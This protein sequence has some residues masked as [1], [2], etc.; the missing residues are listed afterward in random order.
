MS[1]YAPCCYNDRD[2]SMTARM[3]VQDTIAVKTGKTSLQEDDT[4]LDRHEEMGRS[5]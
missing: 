5:N 1:Y 2:H 3:A 4:G